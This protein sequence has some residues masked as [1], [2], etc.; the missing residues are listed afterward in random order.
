MVPST[1]SLKREM[2]GLGSLNTICPLFSH[3]VFEIKSERRGGG[4]SLALL[5]R[6]PPSHSWSSEASMSPLL[7]RKANWIRGSLASHRSFRQGCQRLG[8]WL[9]PICLVFSHSIFKTESERG[10]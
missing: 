4:A 1:I 7:S 9:A 5:G 2:V 6:P 8:M 10:G 3:S